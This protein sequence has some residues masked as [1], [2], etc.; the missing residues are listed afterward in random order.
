MPTKAIATVTGHAY[1]PTELKTRSDGSKYCQV[2]FWTS[3]KPKKDAEKEFTSWSG[4]ASGIEAE[5]LARDLKKGS[6]VQVSGSVRM[7]KFAKADGTT[8]H[9]IEFT[10]IFTAI[11]LD[12]RADKPEPTTAPVAAA[13]P[14][15]R[16]ITDDDGSVPF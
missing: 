16:P 3:D 10:R 9:Q 14:S 11:C 1:G 8:S 2:R 7:A 6:L 4:F 5:W 13:R 15:V 12:E